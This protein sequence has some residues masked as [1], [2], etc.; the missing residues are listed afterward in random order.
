VKSNVQAAMQT[1][2]ERLCRGG[3]G[4]LFRAGRTSPSIEELL[5]WPAVFELQGLNHEQQ[6]LFTLFCLPRCTTLCG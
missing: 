4:R 1:R 3:V 5:R 2:L 6:N